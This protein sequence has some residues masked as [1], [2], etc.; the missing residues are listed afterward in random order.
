MDNI[1]K[2]QNKYK[3][4]KKLD[5]YI[6]VPEAINI[7]QGVLAEQKVAEIIYDYTG[8]TVLFESLK[9]EDTEM[10]GDFVIDGYPD[11]FVDVKGFKDYGERDISDYANEKLRKIQSRYPQGRLA[12]IN[13]YTENNYTNRVYNDGNIIVVDGIYDGHKYKPDRINHL[14]QWIRSKKE[15]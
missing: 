6:L 14:L 8:G 4:D 13:C 10:L 2:Y 7:L 1:L 11:T 3:W 5:L 9:L 12:I 15:L